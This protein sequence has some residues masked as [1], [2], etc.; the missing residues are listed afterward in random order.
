MGTSVQVIDRTYGH[1]AK[2]QAERAR[3]R[4]NRRPSI[5]AAEAEAVADRSGVYLVRDALS[6][7]AE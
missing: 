5:S 3:D 7:A 4:L 2:D 6:R 1:L